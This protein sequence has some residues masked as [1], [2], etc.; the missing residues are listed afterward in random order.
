MMKII[1]H[2]RSFCHVGRN[3]IALVDVNQVAQDCFIL[4]GEQLRAHSVA[5][6]L[7]LCTE[8]FPVLADANELEQVVLNLI[9]NARDALEG[10][11]QATISLRSWCEA[12]QFHLEIR[13]NGPGIPGDLVSRVFDPFFT[14]KEPGKGT[15]LGL[16]ISH[17]ILRKYQGTIRVQN[18][19]GAVFTITLPLASYGEKSP[20]LAA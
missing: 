2:M 14:T 15:G 10:R 4:I 16:S 9:S 13:D 5:V 3:E 17:S 7:D 12:D 1:N 6:E 18:D 8:A 11:P 19:N 20:A